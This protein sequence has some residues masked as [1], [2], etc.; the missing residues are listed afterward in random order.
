MLPRFQSRIA[1]PPVGMIEAVIF[2]MDGVIVDTEQLWERARE[3]LTLERGG[4]WREEAQRTM[5]GM[6]STEW[7]EYMHDELGV[8]DEPEWISAEVVRRLADLYR[9]RLPIL[10][11]AAE[12]VERLASRWPLGVASSSNRPLINLVLELTRLDAYFGITVS[13]EEVSRGKP[14]PD[15][16]LAAASGLDIAP[17]ACAAVEDSA[18]GIRAAANAGMYVIAIPSAAFPP[19]PA[20]MAHADLTLGSASELDAD[21]I[22]RLER[23]DR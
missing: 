8:R 2:D 17:T 18:N 10:D 3:Q 15:V 5:M 9:E 23:G 13:S 12:A 22:A 19:T 1:Y 11:G 20:A 21:L 7:S 16:Y 4:A 6:S 14:A